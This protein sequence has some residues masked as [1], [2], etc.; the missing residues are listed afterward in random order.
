M[1]RTMSKV[2]VLTAQNNVPVQVELIGKFHLVMS[3]HVQ[4]AQQKEPMIIA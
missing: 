2:Q 1:C 3:E 4:H